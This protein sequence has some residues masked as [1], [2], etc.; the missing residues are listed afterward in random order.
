MEWGQAKRMNCKYLLNQSISQ[1]LI[2][3][4]Q[5]AAC[6]NL[7]HQRTYFR[8]LNGAFVDLYTLHIPESEP[9]YV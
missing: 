7:N 3:K 6:F 4:S 9:K 2:N 1:Y 5:S 8:A